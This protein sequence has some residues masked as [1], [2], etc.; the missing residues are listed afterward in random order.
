MTDKKNNTA[1][2]VVIVV[3]VLM[4][5]GAASCFCLFGAGMVGGLGM[6]GSAEKTYYP[7]CEMLDDSQL[8]KECCSRHGHNGHASGN[9]IN[10]DGKLCGC[11]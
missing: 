7:A 3:V 1:M 6:I 10:E 4:G 11:F 9:L 2:I 5:L 8:C